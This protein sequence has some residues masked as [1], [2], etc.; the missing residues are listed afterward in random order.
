MPVA[1]VAR[2]EWLTARGP[3]LLDC[4]RIAG[5]LNITPDSFWHGGRHT[6]LENA[7][8]HAARMIEDGAD[9]LDIG[10]ESTR[11]GAEPISA[12]EE[13][14]RV[15]PVVSE[16]AR[17]F[18]AVPI[19][20]D[21]VKA[22][23]AR[24][25]LAEG[26]AIVNDV[27]GLRLDADLGSVVAH[28]G[29]G[30]ILMHSRGTVDRMASYDLAEYG[31]DPV[32]AIA[33][34]LSGALARAAMAG[35]A[36]ERIVLDP[37]LGFAKRT[38]HS[39]AVLAHLDRI[40]ALGHPVLVGPSRKRFVGELAGGLPPVERLEGTLAACVAAL[41]KGARLFRVHDVAALRRALDVAEAIRTAP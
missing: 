11:P 1:P 33:D 19:S 8:A 25:V 29:A 30:L 4:P 10:G 24:A 6:A 32:A 16:L 38:E 31:P 36:P 2:F 15:V 23:V 18:P 3:I 27:S 22:E 5:I 12:A 41:F 21:T 28:A 39:L 35:V 7:I 9:L 40:L 13:R 14:S 20:V 17:R 34:E 37:G 26:A